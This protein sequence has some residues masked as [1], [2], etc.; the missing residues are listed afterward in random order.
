MKYLSLFSGIGGFELG[1]QQAYETNTNLFKP[2]E[3][4]EKCTVSGSRDS[5]D[6]SSINGNRGWSSPTCIGFSEIDKY[7][8][9]TYQ[10]HY[11]EHKNYGDITK[12][13][14]DELPD[15]DLLVGGFPC[16]AFSIAGKRLGFEDTRGTL[17]FEIARIL[18]AKQ[19]RLF[20]L[21]NVKGLL[22]SRTT[23]TF[24]G[25][26][27]TLS[28]ELT[29]N[30]CNEIP[31]K[32]WEVTL[33]NLSVYLQQIGKINGLQKN[34]KSLLERNLPIIKKQNFYPTE[35]TRQFAL[36]ENEWV[37]HLNQLSLTDNL[38]I[39]DIPLLEK[40]VVMNGEIV[41]LWKE[42][43]VE[44]SNQQKLSTISTET[45]WMTDL[46]TCISAIQEVN[47]IL[48]I[49]KQWKLSNNYW[50]K[51]NSSSKKENTYYVKTF[52]IIINELTELG[53][54]LQWQVLNS[55]NHGVPQNRERV[56]IVGHLRGT[57]RPEVFPITREG[58]QDT[59]PIK[60]V[61]GIYDSEKGTHQ[62][63]SV[64]DSSGISATLDTMQGGNRMPYVL[65]VK[66]IGTRKDSN[67]GTQP[68]QQDRVYDPTGVSPALQQALPEGG[69][70]ILVREATKKGYAEATLGDSINL[71]VPESKTRRGRV[72][73]GVA[74]TLDTGMQQHTISKT[75]RAGGRS[76]PHG[77]KQNWDS[78][79][80]EYGIRRLTPTECE[81]LQGFPDG[82]T[83][84]V[85]DT[86]RYKQCGNAVTVNVIRDIMERLL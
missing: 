51:I 83:E 31:T 76:S 21:E 3:Q 86:Q 33:H 57:R 49:I 44:N 79:D 24:D 42:L 71:S 16:Q 43:L 73:K 69:H 47:I 23:L 55:K 14:A 4:S 39:L 84:G 82:W 56:F 74:Q 80:T 58:G 61:G 19:P 10:Q 25:I 52:N 75:I 72:G 35:K 70:K 20:L 46:K 37:S 12:I 32:E 8:I 64:F 68:F 77:S 2:Q 54:D 30:I 62:A 15:F 81:R 67:S 17:F 63:G 27:D 36:N 1:I 6:T 29:L 48:F 28:N 60:R 85:S 34:L 13:N 41:V 7:A 65:E 50:N 45:N 18:Q 26:L 66:Q 78:Y 9:Q 59:K 40:M 38:N 22:S 11:P 53:Y 5:T